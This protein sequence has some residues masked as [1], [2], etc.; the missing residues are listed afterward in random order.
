[1]NNTT[2]IYVSSNKEKQG[3]EDKTRQTLLENSGGLPIVSV[4]QKP[5]DLGENICVGDVGASGFNFCRQV[6]IA[7]EN[8]KT[9]FVISAESDCIY[10]PDYFEFRPDRLD[11]PYRNTNI[12]VQKYM[13]DYACKKH[14]STFAQIVG[15]EFYIKRL[16]MLFEGQPEW[17]A[18]IKNFPKEIGKMLFDEFEYWESKNPCLSFKTG[19]G[20]RKHSPTGET[21]VFELPYWGSIKILCD[22][23]LKEYAI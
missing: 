7:C 10:P 11:I 12:Y 8:A 6:L 2:I 15:R 14:S 21:K 1:M 17:N 3:F 4:T 16:K 5:I 13:C 23:Y 19:N 9:E 18:S 22:K 20:M